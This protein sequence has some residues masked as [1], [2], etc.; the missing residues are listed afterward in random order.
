MISSVAPAPRCRPNTFAVSNR[1]MPYATA[2]SMIVCESVSDVCGPKFIVP[3]H[4]AADD[5]AE[6]ADVRVLHGRRVYVRPTRTSARR[7]S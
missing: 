6:V 7:G 4:Q 2:V 1:L 5:Q 3:R